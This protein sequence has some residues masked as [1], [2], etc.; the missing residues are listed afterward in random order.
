MLGNTMVTH[1]IWFCGVDMVAQ[2]CTIETT[3]NNQTLATAR[4]L[5][6]CLRKQG[7]HMMNTRP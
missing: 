4:I 2:K 1:D 3:N 5:W 6:D 7:F